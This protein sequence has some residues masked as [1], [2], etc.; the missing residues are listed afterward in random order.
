[1]AS[2]PRFSRRNFLGR[3]AT[4]TLATPLLGSGLQAQE[5]TAPRAPASDNAPTEPGP[6]HV[7]SKPFHSFSY[8]ETAAVIA[9][10]GFAGIDYTV[11]PGGHVAP[12]SVAAD[13]PRAVAAA[14]AAGLRT[15]M[16]VTGIT[17]LET[18]HARDV[19]RTAASLGITTYRLGFLRYDFKLGVH[20]TLARLKPALRALADFNAS[21]G[22]H[23]AIQNHSGLTQVGALGWDLH[24]LLSDVD[25]RWLG[26]QYDV[27]HAVT[28][29]GQSWPIT[30]EILRPW[31][32]STAWKDFRWAQAPGQQSVVNVPLGEGIVDFALY[33]EKVRELRVGGPRSVH[34]EYAPFEPIPTVSPP[35]RR[36]QLLTAMQRDRR[37]LQSWFD[38]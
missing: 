1:M 37:T 38:A 9:E 28:A 34:F 31:I 6:L 10:A 23:G 11:R 7:F 24:A 22:L 2:S 30:L 27:R 15:D 32:R 29:C 19:L 3:L 8:D 21:L 25:P 20:A 13:L 5:R 12:D 16:M 35:E 26:C 4:A 18:P 36:A 33:R 17:S 14:R